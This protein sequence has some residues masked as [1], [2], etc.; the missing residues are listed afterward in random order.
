[1][2]KQEDHLLKQWCMRIA[3]KL[4]GLAPPHKT[5]RKAACPQRGHF[6]FAIIHLQ[7]LGHFIERPRRDITA[8][9]RKHCALSISTDLRWLSAKE[10]RVCVLRTGV[11][12]N[13]ELNYKWNQLLLWFANV[14][15]LI[16]SSKVTHD[17][18]VGALQRLCTHRLHFFFFNIRTG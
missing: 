13:F 9:R 5:P 12:G 15:A 18:N 16:L 6:S 2:W 11:Y 10:Q 17:V 4:P 1:M 7:L 14:C 3:F 8:G